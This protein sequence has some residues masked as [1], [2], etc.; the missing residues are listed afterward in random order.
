MLVSVLSFAAT[1]FTVCVCIPSLLIMVDSI[2][3]RCGVRQQFE[4]EAIARVSK[5][6]GVCACDSALLERCSG[7][8]SLDN[9]SYMH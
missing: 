7:A 5:A 1:I 9:K 2:L 3:L 8:C 6:S 4:I